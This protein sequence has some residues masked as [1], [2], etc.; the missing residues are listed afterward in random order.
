MDGLKELVGKREMSE[1]PGFSYDGKEY[2][3]PVQLAELMKDEMFMEPKEIMVKLSDQTDNFLLKILSAEPGEITSRN[4]LVGR[5]FTCPVCGEVK[6]AL[7]LEMI[8]YPLDMKTELVEDNYLVN[9]SR[10]MMV[11]C[12][13]CCGMICFA[14]KMGM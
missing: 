12:K 8:L 4:D 13:K 14:K 5:V 10:K 2:F 1:T 9:V 11:A 3:D 6:S 7:D